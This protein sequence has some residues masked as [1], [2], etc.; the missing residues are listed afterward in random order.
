ML[1]LGGT[2]GGGTNDTGVDFRRG[3]ANSIIS[4]KPK[5]ECSSSNF[6]IDESL[7]CAWMLRL[8]V[9]ETKNNEHATGTK[10]LNVLCRFVMS[11]IF[12]N[13]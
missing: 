4:C 11:I 13:K 9:A 7:A 1:F 2:G 3:T 5:F 6:G 8:V 12:I 10:E